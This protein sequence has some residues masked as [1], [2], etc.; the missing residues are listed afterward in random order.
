MPDTTTPIYHL[1]KP[2]VGAAKDT[3]GSS[4]NANLDLIDTLLRNRLTKT[5]TGLDVGEGLYQICDT[6]IIA[7]E[8]SASAA[9]TNDINYRS[10]TTSRWVESR[11][12]AILN[13][14]FPI[15]T[16]LMWSGTFGNIP[17][18]WFLCNGA[19]GTPNLVD[20]VVVCAGNQNLPG[21][22]GG[23]I[24]AGQKGAVPPSHYHAGTQYVPYE[25]GGPEFLDDYGGLP[26]PIYGSPS[27]PYYTVCFIMKYVNWGP[28]V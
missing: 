3:W 23:V 15:G 18:G 24:I 13:H 4:I 2:E 26:V 22:F 10:L 1:T 21:E 14:F 11:I 5:L 25:P 7:A 16:I 27:M 19:Y 17:A 12:H 20:R 28:G 6:H 9:G 8:Q